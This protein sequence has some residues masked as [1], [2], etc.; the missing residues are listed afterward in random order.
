MEKFLNWLGSNTT[1]THGAQQAIA[2][3]SSPVFSSDEST[4]SFTAGHFTAN[5]S[6]AL[7]LSTA[8]EKLN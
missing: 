8:N 7:P 3:D 2:Y 4:V 1:T 5:Q 6:S